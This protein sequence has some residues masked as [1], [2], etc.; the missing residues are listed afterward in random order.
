MGRLGRGAAGHPGDR[1]ALA[2]GGALRARRDLGGERTA[3]EAGQPP[4]G[5]P[6][7]VVSFVV[8]LF[9]EDGAPL[10]RAPNLMD[11]VDLFLE[12]ELRRPL[13]A[14]ELPVVLILRVPAMAEDSWFG[15]PIRN[16]TPEY[17]YMT[18]FVKRGAHIVYR[19]PHPVMEVIAGG[20]PVWIAREAPGQPRAAAF[21][22]RTT[23]EPPPSGVEPRRRRT[24]RTSGGSR[25]GGSRIR[26]S[27]SGPSRS[28]RPPCAR[29]APSPRRRASDPTGEPTDPF[30]RVYVAES[31][32]RELCG[33]RA[34]SRD[35]EEGGFLFG[36]VYRDEDAPE[37]Y[38][39]EVTH[40]A[41]AEHTGA[42][43]LH[44][45]FS[46]ESFAS[47]RRRLQAEA[48]EVKL[49]GWWHTHLFGASSS[50]GL[51]TVDVRLHF[52]TFRIP[53]Q[54]AG[55]VNPT[56]PRDPA[57]RVLR[58]YVRRDRTMIRCP[59]RGAPVSALDAAR[60]VL[61][62]AR[63][64]RGAPPFAHPAV[65]VHAPRLGAPG[66]ASGGGGG[67]GGGA[68]G[69]ACGRAALPGPAAGG[70]EPAG[71]G[72]RAARGGHR[73]CRVPAVRVGPPGGRVPAADR[74]VGPRPAPCRRGPG[75]PRADRRGGRRRPAGPVAAHAPSSTDLRRA[76]EDP[77]SRW[78]NLLRRHPDGRRAI[79][80]AFATP[81]APARS[82]PLSRIR[83]GPPAHHRRR[84][85]RAR[86]R[87][88]RGGAGPPSRA[89]ARR[90]GGGVD[91]RSPGRRWTTWRSATRSRW[92]GWWGPLWAIRRAFPDE[93]RR[94]PYLDADGIIEEGR[95]STRSRGR[96]PEEARREG[97]DRARADGRCPGLPGQAARLPERDPRRLPAR[98]AGVLA[99]A[100]STRRSS[101]A[102]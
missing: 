55:L 67:R 56:P 64:P 53:W 5:G 96:S 45:T 25:S 26:R 71:P 42:S 19:H 65:L 20:L 80:H 90:G 18:I 61:A 41:P 91:A 102:R 31:V 12:Q 27:A 74:H 69:G 10:D 21:A 4:Q 76:A 24:P 63:D 62:W 43:L 94:R 68:R 37:R 97:D 75:A 93:L 39:V 73:L 16:A 82:P 48:S 100:P 99:P 66:V 35:A 57:G 79:V 92:P 77:R 54:I 3:S 98:G 36:R 17:G 38:L 86:P 23:D 32:H 83:D 87:R 9:G 70:R 11:V 46:G 51:S 52:T 6:V 30:V 59:E 44:L 85:A 101:S 95:S 81:G 22:F 15:G 28:R 50:L 33:G 47:M 13:G 58:F 34:F 7:R 88:L 49:V 72:G 1:R 60:A 89:I 84:G 8:Q 40:A 14:D 2:R 78:S 29:G